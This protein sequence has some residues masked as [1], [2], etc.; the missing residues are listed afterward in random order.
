MCVGLTVYALKTKKDFTMM[1][2]FM[3]ILIFTSCFLG[4]TL[5]FIRSPILYALYSLIG[6]CLASLY[7]LYDVQLIF[8][9]KHERARKLSQEDYVRG[10]LM[11]YLDVIYMFMQILRLLGQL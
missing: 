1:G 2:G 10:A 5:W 3:W 6:V 8:Q 4:L 11:L 7:V 9:G